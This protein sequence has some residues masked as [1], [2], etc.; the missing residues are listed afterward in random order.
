[1]DLKKKMV[2]EWMDGRVAVRKPVLKDYQGQSFYNV[3]VNKKWIF[4]QDCANNEILEAQR[5]KHTEL[6]F[7][8]KGQLEVTINNLSLNVIDT[9]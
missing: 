5:K 1:M 3:T 4:F 8:L 2:V 7:Q 9:S 6:I